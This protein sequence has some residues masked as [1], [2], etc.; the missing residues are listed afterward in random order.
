MCLYRLEHANEDSKGQVENE[1]LAH[2]KERQDA[3]ETCIMRPGMVL[4]KETNV[5]SLVFGLGPS[6]RVDVLAAVMLDVALKGSEQQILENSEINHL[7]S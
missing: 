4:S 5:R 6:V 1:L 7:R 3:F 2:A